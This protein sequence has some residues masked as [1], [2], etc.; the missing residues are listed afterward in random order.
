MLK[1]D[2]HTHPLAHKHYPDIVPCAKLDEH[3]KR[4]VEAMIQWGISR[5]LDG[6]AITDHNQ[7]TS[8]LSD[9]QAALRLPLLPVCRQAR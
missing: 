2:F 5:G 6:I 4:A 1:I 3:D 7:F 9:D 8:G